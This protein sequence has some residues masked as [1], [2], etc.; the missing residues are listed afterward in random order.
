[1]D[2]LFHKNL[3]QEKSNL[4]WQLAQA[5]FKIKNL[6]EQLNALKRKMNEE[7][8]VNPGSVP[9]STTP[10]A[11]MPSPSS[12]APKPTPMPNPKIPAE[13]YDWFRKK[14]GPMT[15]NP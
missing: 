7:I 11:P 3:L 2:N 13:F 14:F 6:E 5:N 8:G 15:K 9:P 10:P 4:E 12:P 1:M